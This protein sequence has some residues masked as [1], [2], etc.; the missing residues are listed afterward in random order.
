M[1]LAMAKLALAGGIIAAIIFGWMYHG[2][3]KYEEGKASVQILWDS[4]KK[5]QKEAADKERARDEAARKLIE[6]KHKKE[7]EYAKSEAGKRAVVE[8]IRSIGL[9]SDG[10]TLRSLGDSGQAEGSK[11]A[12]GPA[13]E[14]STSQSIE[15]FAGR[16]AQDA[17]TIINFQEW[18]NQEGI[19]SE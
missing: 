10:S 6:A 18:I 13:C 5:K 8:Y 17:I 14:R 15:E 7:I 1:N 9:L 2:H 16:C 3:V 11:G 4:E 12:D 19:E